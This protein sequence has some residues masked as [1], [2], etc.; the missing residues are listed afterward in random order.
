MAIEDHFSID[1]P[2]EYIQKL[3]TVWQ[4]I[5]YVELAVAVREPVTARAPA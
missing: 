1:L 5:E 2:D 4:G 3:G